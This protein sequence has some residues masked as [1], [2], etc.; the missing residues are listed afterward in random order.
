VPKKTFSIITKTS[1]GMFGYR[2]LFD[3]QS[4]DFLSLNKTNYPELRKNI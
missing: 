1:I 4:M 3:L 2:V